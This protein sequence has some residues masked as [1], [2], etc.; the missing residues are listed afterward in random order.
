LTSAGESRSR[1]R[2][3]LNEELEGS[4]FSSNALMS[5]S[6]VLRAGGLVVGNIPMGASGS[7]TRPQTDF[8]T[9]IEICVEVIHY[10]KP[11][12]VLDLFGFS[13]N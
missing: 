13:K 12:P 1:F 9:S 10:K 5:T 8:E 6:A 11:K 7:K 4:I 3:E 2:L